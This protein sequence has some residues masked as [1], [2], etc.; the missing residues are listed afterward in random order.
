MSFK[1]NRSKSRK[2]VS[3]VETGTGGFSLWQSELQNWTSLSLSIY[4]YIY[5]YTH[6]HTHMLNSRAWLIWKIEHLIF[7]GYRWK[8]P[9]ARNGPRKIYTISIQRI[10]FK[11]ISKDVS[12]IEIFTSSE[13]LEAGNCFEILVNF[14]FLYIDTSQKTVAFPDIA[15]R[16]SD[17]SYKLLSEENVVAGRWLNV[18]TTFWNIKPRFVPRSEHY[19]SALQGPD[20]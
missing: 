10:I 13:H 16:N 12:T 15:M 2:P 11:S 19:V 17:I 8:T 1:W 6:T 14:Y 4:I 3:G 20:F 18:P 5:I 7:E 9:K